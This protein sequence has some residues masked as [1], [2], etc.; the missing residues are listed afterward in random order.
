MAG[1][2]LKISFSS[3]KADAKDALLIG[4]IIF[5][6]QIVFTL[7]VLEVWFG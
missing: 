4:S 3:I 6:I 1:V 5:A 7:S 2:G